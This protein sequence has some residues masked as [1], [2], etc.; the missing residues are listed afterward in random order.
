[1]ACLIHLISEFSLVA[2]HATGGV[3][4]RMGLADLLRQ[5]GFGL[6]LRAGRPFRPV[7]VFAVRQALHDAQRAHGKLSLI[8]L[9]EFVDDMDV[10]SLS[11]CPRDW[12]NFSMFARQVAGRRTAP[13]QQATL[14]CRVLQLAIV[15]RQPAPENHDL[16]SFRH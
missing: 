15:Q 1:M 11:K 5:H 4:G 12:G 7:A 16:D 13:D 2:L 10:F 14:I 3:A 8:R 9:H 6:G